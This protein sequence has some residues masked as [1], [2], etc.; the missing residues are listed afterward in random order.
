MHWAEWRATS[1]SR[2]KRQWPHLGRCDATDVTRRVLA[3]LCN[4]CSSR[5]AMGHTPFTS[6][7][8][9]RLVK[10][11]VTHNSDGKGRKGNA[12]YQQLT[13]DVRGSLILLPA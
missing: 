2:Q 10:Y 7:D 12:I 9:R 1:P 5:A 8:E 13:T 4:A 3:S 6:A 11:L